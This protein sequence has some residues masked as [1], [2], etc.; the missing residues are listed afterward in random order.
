MTSG[1]NTVQHILRYA[2]FIVVIFS[3][4]FL[5]EWNHTENNG[6]RKGKLKRSKKI[7]EKR[8]KIFK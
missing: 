5:F 1:N 6:V 8:L 3:L 4:I 7:D 2:G